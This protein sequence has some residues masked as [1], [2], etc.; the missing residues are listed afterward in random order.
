M[1]TIYEMCGP[2]IPNWST[3]FVLLSVAPL[4]FV[5]DSREVDFRDLH[6]EISNHG[7]FEVDWTIFKFSLKKWLSLGKIS[8]EKS[9]KCSKL[10]KD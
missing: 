3:D 7:D 8:G 2:C 4:P 5:D 6:A 10:K 9:Q 1:W